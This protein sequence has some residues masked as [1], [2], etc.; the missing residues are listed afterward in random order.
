ME[1]TPNEMHAAGVDPRSPQRGQ[2]VHTYA[3]GSLGYN[4]KKWVSLRGQTPEAKRTELLDAI[5]AHIAVHKM[6][7]GVHQLCEATGIRSTSTISL[8]LKK[9]ERQG[10]IKR[11]GG[12]KLIM[13][14]EGCCAFC[15]QTIAEE[16]KQ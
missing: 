16:A 15:G 7:P 12:L 6:P 13:S 11:S 8:A 3:H 14:V 9:L 1:P 4:G 5:K 10:H 2:V